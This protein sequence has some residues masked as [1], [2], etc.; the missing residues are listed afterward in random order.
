[1]DDVA[2]VAT[3]KTQEDNIRLLTKAAEIIF[4]WAYNNAV[5]FDDSKSELLHFTR[6]RSTPKPM[7]LPNGTEIAPSTALR[8]LGV[9]L[10]CKLTF[11]QHVATKMAAA[12]RALAG[13]IRL[14][15]TEKGLNIGNMRQLYQACVVPISDFGSEIWWK[16]FGQ[17]HL[18]RK[19]QLLQN[20]ATRRILG[21]FRTT[22][23]AL[24]D[25]ESSLPP[26][27]IR[28]IHAQRRYAIRL[29]RLTPEHPVVRRCPQ[30]FHPS[31]T[32]ELE[33][34]SDKG[35]P[36]YAKGKQSTSLLRILHSVSSWISPASK[37]EEVATPLPDTPPL[38]TIDL[39]FAKTT[40]IEAAQLHSHLSQTLGKGNHMVAYTDGSLLEGR[41]GAGVYVQPKR[42]TPIKTCYSLGTTAEVFD[43]EL[44]ACFK[45]CERM[46]EILPYEPRTVKDCWVFL[47][48]SAAISRLSHLKPGAGQTYAIEIH[49]IAKRLSDI[50]VRL[51]IHWVPGHQGVPG[52]EIADGLAKQGSTLHTP[53][54]CVVTYAHLRRHVKATALDDWHQKWSHRK[55]ALLY[56]GSPNKKVDPAMATASKR[57]AARVIQIRSGHGYF[58]SYLANIPASSVLTSSCPC[59]NPRQTAE[60][61]V[62]FCTRYKQAR[63][64]HLREWIVESPGGSRW[65]DVYCRKGTQ[66]LLSFL[67]ATSLCLRPQT[68]A[69]WVPGL[70]SLSQSEEKG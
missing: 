8:W 27:E 43:A 66:A 26:V 55:T 31:G 4:R 44:F 13:L 59:G 11:N 6:A 53:R 23:I 47:D 3:G 16:G 33:D 30:D 67:I 46:E 50:N 29:L 18:R 49:K 28:L 68:A 45:A 42:Q 19:L 37:L 32:G 69:D 40:K 65:M 39:S 1:M 24:L 9:W 2:V 21:A 35:C 52:N 22:P 54:E 38:A 25:V 20:K 56:E 17:D 58:N 70:G 5:A 7:R 61:L 14:S 15:S 60:H 36:W 64:Q 51:H 12:E 41:V 62:L 34:E 57:E 63:R 48:N 10:D